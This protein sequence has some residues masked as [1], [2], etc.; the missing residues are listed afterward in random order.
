M[1]GE[2]MDR[3][4]KDCQVGPKIAKSGIIINFVTLTRML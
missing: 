2:L 4:K 1:R 3:A